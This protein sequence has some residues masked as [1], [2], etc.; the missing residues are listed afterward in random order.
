MPRALGRLLVGL[1]LVASGFAV[2]SCG[3][4]T[5]G[6]GAPH[7]PSP[8]LMT[9]PDL[10][11]F[12][13]VSVRLGLDPGSTVAFGEGQTALR[14]AIAPGGEQRVVIDADPSDAARVQVQVQEGQLQIDL[15]GAPPA[16]PVQVAI[17]VPSLTQVSAFGGSVATIAPGFMVGDVAIRADTGATVSG[18]LQATGTVGITTASAGT[19]TLDGT[20]T[21]L[22]ASAATGSF[23]HAFGLSVPAVTVVADTGALVEVTPGSTLNA[24]AATGARVVY[25]GAP[26]TVTPVTDT[27]G[28][29]SPAG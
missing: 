12:T 22:N 26:A 11:P 16:G 15:S 4:S 20:A 21:A 7:S 17:T 6:S 27:G 1:L 13:A 29:V 28:T 19:A 9:V 8:S 18:T 3:G 24:S 10:P 5:S 2:A 14:A 25:R 23:I